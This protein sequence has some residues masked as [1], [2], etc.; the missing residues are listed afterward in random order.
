MIV[1]NVG[2]DAVDATA[3]GAKARWTKR[4]LRTAK[5]CGPDTPTL[6]SSWRSNP[7]ATVARKP[8]HRGEHDISRKTIA[9]GMP[10]VPGY[11]YTRV[12]STFYLC[13]RGRGCSGHPAFPCALSFWAKLFAQLGRTGMDRRIGIGAI[14]RTDLESVVIRVGLIGW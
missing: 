11:L 10:G 1:T 9:Q 13:T 5:S 6:V 14:A 7:L 12:L 3:S 8:G 4:L 2:W